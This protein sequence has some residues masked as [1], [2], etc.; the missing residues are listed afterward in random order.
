M[1]PFYKSVT[2]TD[3]SPPAQL[4]SLSHRVSPVLWWLMVW[5]PFH[6]CGADHYNLWLCAE[7]TVHE[8]KWW[9]LF[10]HLFKRQ[11]TRKSGKFWFKTKVDSEKE[12]Y[13]KYFWSLKL[14]LQTSLPAALPQAG[15]CGWVWCPPAAKG[16]Q[17]RNNYWSFP[18]HQGTGVTALVCLLKWSSLTHTKPW[19][20]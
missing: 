5:I 10:P 12:L 14:L 1:F 15:L 8:K 20:E 18:L 9:L 3:F 2:L 16:V 17:V 7:V 6:V 13:I 19:P 4:M 11:R